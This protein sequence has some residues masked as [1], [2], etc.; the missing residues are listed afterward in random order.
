MQFETFQLF[1]SSSSATHTHT[2]TPTCAW[3]ASARKGNAT[4]SGRSSH[5]TISEE[6]REKVQELRESELHV[7][8]HVVQ[9]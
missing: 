4:I 8:T 1:E 3:G 9:I 7:P 5:Q 2:R 6:E